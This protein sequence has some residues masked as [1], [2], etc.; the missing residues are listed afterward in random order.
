MVGLFFV[1]VLIS[2][3][4]TF[5]ASLKSCSD[6]RHPFFTSFCARWLAYCPE[7]YFSCCCWK[8]LHLAPFTPILLC[9]LIGAIGGSELTL[10]GI[11]KWTKNPCESWIAQLK[12]LLKCPCF[13]FFLPKSTCFW[14]Q[15]PLLDYHVLSLTFESQKI[16]LE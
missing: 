8:S 12:G 11:T 3:D 10:K 2:Y 13:F 4:F 7:A 16:L 1:V 14:L 6:I 5:A 9:E 15:P